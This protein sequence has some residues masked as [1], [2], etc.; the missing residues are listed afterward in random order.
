MLLLQLR[1]T[2]FVNYS[3]IRCLSSSTTTT[4]LRDDWSSTGEV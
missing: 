1:N 2:R 4:V 3:K